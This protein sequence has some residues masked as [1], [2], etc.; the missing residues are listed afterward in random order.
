VWA[1]HVPVIAATITASV[2]ITTPAILKL[3]S[4]FVKLKA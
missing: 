1:A 3:Y 4:I 2:D